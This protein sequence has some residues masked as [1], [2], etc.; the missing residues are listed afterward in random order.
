VKSYQHDCLKQEL[1]KRIDRLM[2]TG[3]SQVG[4]LNTKQGAR[5]LEEMPRA[6][7]IIVLS[8][9]YIN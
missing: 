4:D 3:E 1:L 8:K 5:G 6:G 9:N 7:E 2:W